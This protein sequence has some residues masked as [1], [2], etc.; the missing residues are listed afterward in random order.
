MRM[1]FETNDG[2][3]YVACEAD[4]VMAEM[5]SNG[6][7]VYVK[8]GGEMFTVGH[9]FTKEQAYRIVDALDEKGRTK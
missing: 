1:R 4:A 5:G 2:F 7:F 9:N 3:N 6:W 8:V